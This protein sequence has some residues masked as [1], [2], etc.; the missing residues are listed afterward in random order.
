LRLTTVQIIKD[1]SCIVY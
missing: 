1:M